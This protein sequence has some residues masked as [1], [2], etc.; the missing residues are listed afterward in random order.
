MKGKVENNPSVKR[1]I[2]G[3]CHFG[4]GLRVHVEGSE[5]AK[6]EGDPQH[7][8]SK[9]FICIKGKAALDF[10]THPKRINYPLKRVGRRGEDKWERVSWRQAMDE[11]AEKIK[12]IK[13]EYGPEAV[14][15]ISGNPHEPGD[16][17]LWKW[18]NLFGTPNYMSQ[19]RN[20]GV[21]EY[22]AECA[23]YGYTASKGP[24]PGVTK[25]AVIWGYNPANSNPPALN[26]ILEAKKKG[27]KLIVIDPRLS[28]TASQADLW[29][30]LRPGTDGALALAMLN[31]IVNEELYDE[32]F[33]A[34]WC[35]GFDELRNYVQ[36]YSP[37]KGAE[38]T[39]VPAD[40]IIEAARLYANLRPATL[41]W[42]VAT[43]HVARSGKSG[44]QAKAI[45]RAITGNLDVKGGDVLDRPP[46]PAKY[47][48]FENIHWDLLANHP[49][50]HRDNVSADIFPIT[51]IKGYK[52]FREAMKKVHRNGYGTPM[53]MLVP[54]P[55]CIYR[56]V[57]E[58]K[59]YPIKAIFTQGSN[60]LAV[61]AQSRKLY[62][63][64]LS[65]KLVLHVVME[66]FMTPTAQ[67]ADYVLPAA[68][69]LERPQIKTRWGLTDSY[70]LGDQSVTPLY[71][72]KD[73]YQ[74]WRQLGIRL[75]QEEHWPETLD[76][77]FDKF[78]EPAGLTFRE[79]MAREDHWFIP[80]QEYKKYE[81]EGFATYSGKVEFN[82]SIFKKL[83][84]DPLPRYE[85]PTRSPLSTPEL[86]KAYPLVLISGSRVRPFTH[87]CFRQIKRLR[88]VHPDPR[89]EIH[90]Q[91]AAELGISG[92]DWVY[93]ET[94]EGRVKQKAKLTE[95]I[96]PRVVHADGY[97]WYPE[98]PG[99]IPQLFDIWESNINMIF[100]DDPE[101][102]D[103]AGDNYFRALLCKVYK[104]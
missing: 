46:N 43:C 34:K 71:A 84:L 67:L 15:A 24:L 65:D 97:W 63:A 45:L 2:C 70:F 7:P 103:Y 17:A 75:D 59:P 41:S 93:I 36:E 33:V 74:L 79:L 62:E 16:W 38:I 6:I 25:C 29:L 77:M 80:L 83:G 102:C 32:N 10:H 9:G 90:P 61:F 101:F 37:Q 11:I 47:A 57:T 13:G 21:S 23:V 94:I 44:S 76:K 69:W 96:D 55:G 48:W 92:G 14:A 56:A 78:L 5:I 68:D 89:L 58:E 31:V 54:S 81:K 40:K 100:P 12:E 28:E 64:Y 22:L 73:D 4:C 50:R 3:M 8:V 1:T 20:C 85:E 86:A 27:M 35:S 104:P 26:R 53:Y 95:S 52:L 60:P 51:S 66:L 19:G 49:E 88:R 39:W 99:K 98:R 30:Q 82:P 42:G 87:S 72:R 18:C 91:T